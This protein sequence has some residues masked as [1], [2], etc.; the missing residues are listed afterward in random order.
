M[1]VPQPDDD[2]HESSYEA[3]TISMTS[4]LYTA[5]SVNTGVDSIAKHLVS[6]ATK[7]PISRTDLD[8]YANMPVVGMHAT[9]IS[10]T[11]RIAD[12]SPYTPDY[13]S[14][15]VKIVDVAV[16]YE[17]PYTG[18]EYVLIIRNALHVPNMSNNL[19][20]PFMLREIGI[21]VKDTP[22]IHCDGPT[23]NRDH[24]IEFPETGFKIP[25]LLW[26]VFS[27]F[28]TSK[29]TEEFLQETE[30]VYMLTPNHWNPHDEAFAHNEASMIDWEGNM[31][32]PR[33][34]Q[35]ILLSEVPVD[36]WYE[37]SSV[38]VSSAENERI[39]QKFEQLTLNERVDSAYGG[40]PR[41]CNE[42]ASPVVAISPTL[43][44]QTLYECMSSRAK[45]GDIQIAPGSTN[46][47]GGDFLHDN[48]DDQQAGS[49]LD[50]AT[51]EPD[52]DMELDQLYEQSLRGEVDLDEIVASSMYANKSRGVDA[53]HLPKI[54][55]IDHEVAKKT[56]AITFQHSKRTDNP[57]LSQNY[58]TGDRM[59]C[60]KRINDYFFMD[61]FFSTKKGGKSSRG[62]TCCQLFVTD[63]G[64]VY[65]VP[66]RNKSEVLQAV[67][68]FAKEVGAP[69]A[70]ISDMS[71]EQTSKDLRKFCAEIGTT[72][73]FFEEGTPWSN[74]AELYIGLI[75]EAVRKDMQISN[76]PWFSGTIVLKGVCASI[77]SQQETQSDCVGQTLTPP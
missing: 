6:S 54:W 15:K 72:L 69:D 4:H 7:K 68:L 29:P 60:Y 31:V 12:V 32:E 59:L 74:K 64:F 33:D 40:F 34:S 8:S 5:M 14:M 48:E 49:D 20:P 16:K 39:D 30:E 55:R 26:G 66:M 35:Q 37:A 76:C 75:K 51:M 22:K 28:P 1:N 63:K 13:K 46:P 9:I 52:E 42:L 2:D 43:H 36:D 62:N 38:Q 58:G 50:S 47:F 11:G 70:I 56:L 21:K 77:T 27:Y 3:I 41:G 53:P 18:Q 24:A 19:I 10:D 67:K 57:K 73:K 25:L 61:T 44:G 71:G 65:V 45:L 23:A 17:C